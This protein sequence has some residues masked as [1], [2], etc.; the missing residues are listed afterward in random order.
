MQQAIGNLITIL[1]ELL[2]VHITLEQKEIFRWLVTGMGMDLRMWVYS[3]HP[4]V[5]GT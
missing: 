2:T 5:T 3:A 4:L 1:P